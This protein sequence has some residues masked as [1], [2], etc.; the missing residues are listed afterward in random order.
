[1]V[2]KV[3]ALRG[4][5]VLLESILAGRLDRIHNSV[6]LPDHFL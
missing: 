3:H 5:L 1:M 4:E 2:G 6:G